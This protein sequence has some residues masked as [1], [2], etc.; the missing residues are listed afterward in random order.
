MFEIAQNITKFR[1]V[2]ISLV[3]TI[4]PRMNI[5]NVNLCITKTNVFLIEDYICL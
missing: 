5:L 4:N 3:F 1:V 2:A